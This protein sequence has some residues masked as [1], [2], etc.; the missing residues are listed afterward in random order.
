MTKIVV[1]TGAASGIGAACLRALHERGWTAVGLDRNGSDAAKDSA[2]RACAAGDPPVWHCDVSDPS[3]VAEAASRVADVGGAEALVNIAGVLRPGTIDSLDPVAFR[4]M[5]DVNLVGVLH[6]LQAFGPQLVD[7]RGGVVTVASNSAGVPRTGIGAYGATK[8]AA[9][10]LTRSFG[11]ENAVAGVRA[12]VVHPG[13]TRTPMLES[14]WADPS[15]EQSTLGGDLDA[16]RVGIPLRRIAE[17]VDIAESVAF[18]LAP[19][20]RHITMQE[21]YVDGGASLRS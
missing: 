20:A 18:L 13:S 1:V 17:P 11:L 8:A 19:E 4:E 6:C 12:N 16:Y 9:A 14:L 7:R 5:V 2:A 10:M 21:L 15:G 3:D